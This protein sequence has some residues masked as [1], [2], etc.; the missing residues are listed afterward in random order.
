MSTQGTWWASDFRLVPATIFPFC[1]P[2]TVTLGF[3][4]DAVVKN[5]PGNIGDA[6][7]AGW[8]PGSGRSPGGG[9]GNLLQYSCLENPINRRLVGYSPWSRKELYTIQWLSTH[10]LWLR[11]SRKQW[12]LPK[13][14]CLLQDVPAVLSLN[15]LQGGGCCV[16]RYA[17]PPSQASVSI[18]N[19][20]ISFV[21][22]LQCFF[23][24]LRERLTPSFTMILAANGILIPNICSFGKLHSF[25]HRLPRRFCWLLDT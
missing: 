3:P 7:A 5:V 19:P 13:P 18:I 20:L 24:T 12:N 2:L 11:H 25:L 1:P 21:E 8:I 14:S 4:G 17:L 16:V 9:N 10:C 6:R 23:K 22:I 15:S